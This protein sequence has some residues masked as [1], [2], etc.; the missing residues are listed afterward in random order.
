MKFYNNVNI[1]PKFMCVIVGY[2]EAIVKD[3]ETGIYII[4]ITSL[5]P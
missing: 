4:P 3:N 2:Y 5:K 1:K